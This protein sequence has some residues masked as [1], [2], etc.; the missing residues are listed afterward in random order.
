MLLVDGCS[1]KAEHPLAI[2]S[3][4]SKITRDT[5]MLASVVTLLAVPNI[6]VSVRPVDERE[7]HTHELQTIP[8]HDLL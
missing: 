7:S 8:N 2:V 1:K 5:I 6:S 4:M 3:R